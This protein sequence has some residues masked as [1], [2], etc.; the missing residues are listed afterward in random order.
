MHIMYARIAMKP[1]WEQLAV[2]FNQLENSIAH[3]DRLQVPMRKSA[4]LVTPSRLSFSEYFFCGRLEK[5]YA[6][7]QRVAQ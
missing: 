3:F 5:S 1:V 7:A 4:I 2:H 6:G